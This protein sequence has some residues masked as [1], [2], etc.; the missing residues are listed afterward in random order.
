MTH[1]GAMRPLSLQDRCHFG[2]AFSRLHPPDGG[3][4]QQTS[5]I[6]SRR[7]ILSKP[8]M[9]FLIEEPSI[10][11]FLYPVVLVWKHNEAAWNPE[12]L[13]HTPVFQCLVERDSEVVLPHRKQNGRVEVLRSTDG[14]LF[15]PN[16]SLFP[17]RPT[18]I[19]LPKVDGVARA[20]LRLQ[21]D[22][23]GVANETAIA[24][25]RCLQPVGEMSAIA[26]SRCCL[27]ASI[28]KGV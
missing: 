6:E 23:S 19:Q 14:V 2:E 12:P 1:T 7:Q 21:I 26:G 22:E 11:P 9:K 17:D 27:S 10:L 4:F 24:S 16:L 20:P 18:V 3:D 5:R 28:N 8:G 13:Q 25:R 15:S